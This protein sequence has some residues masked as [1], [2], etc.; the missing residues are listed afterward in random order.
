[1]RTHCGLCTSKMHEPA[2]ASNLK[3]SAKHHEL[4]SHLATSSTL[5]CLFICQ[6][7][8]ARPSLIPSCLFA[9]FIC[10]VYLHVTRHTT[11]WLLC[12]TSPLN[13]PLFCMH[14]QTLRCFTCTLNTKTHAILNSHAMQ[15]RF[16][17]QHHIN[18]ETH[19]IL[20]PA[21]SRRRTHS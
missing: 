1:M 12:F 7:R 10:T 6:Q 9:L 20:T 18:A 21:R 5:R 17:Y 13:T 8:K 14:S 2:I 16:Q 11:S 4:N 19:A 15:H 3:D